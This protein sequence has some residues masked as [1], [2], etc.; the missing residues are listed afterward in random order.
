MPHS[1]IVLRVFGGIGNQLFSYAAA[2]RLALLNNVELVL[3]HVS[4]FEFDIE[5]KRQFQLNRF[6]IPCRKA[7]AF[8]RLEPFSRGRRFIKR[9]LN[10]KI[11][12]EKRAYLIQEGVDFDPRLLNFKPKGT[13]HLEGY[14]QSEDYFKDQAEVIRQDLQIIPPVDAENLA[15]ADQIRNTQS[16]AVHLRFF[17]DPQGNSTNNASR[18]YY[19]RAIESME[20]LAPAS[21]YY[22]FSDKP[23]AARASLSLPEERV[24]LVSH[25]RGDENAY[26]DL[27]LMTLCNHFII[28]NSTFSWWGAWLSDSVGKIV[29]APGFECREGI[30][31]WGFKG[32]IPDAWITC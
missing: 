32:L 2:R 3:D 17:D 22:I 14:W 8:E 5:Y 4:G 28:A 30:A 13:V 7:R 24:T 10:Q 29:I 21:H 25:N 6:H 16:V 27:W 20:R 15:M 9:K 11:P 12:F 23:D 1:K 18:E 26:A 31:W 19:A